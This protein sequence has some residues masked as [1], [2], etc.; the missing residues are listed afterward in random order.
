MV[1]ALDE[2]MKVGDVPAI[3][4]IMLLDAFEYYTLRFA[5]TPG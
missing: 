1:E 5:S 4:K 2:I 3:N